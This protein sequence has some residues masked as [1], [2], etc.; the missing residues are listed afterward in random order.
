MVYVILGILIAFL[1]IILIYA[2]CHFKRLK[3]ETEEH[4]HIYFAERNLLIDQLRQQEELQCTTW[5][6]FQQVKEE[7]QHLIE[8]L[9]ELEDFCRN[10]EEKLAQ[11]KNRE[12]KEGSEQELD[13]AIAEK[14]ASI[15]RL[16]EV[17]VQYEEVAAQIKELM[18]EKLKVEGELE[19]TRSSFE[20]ADRKVRRIVERYQATLKV[21]DGE[22]DGWTFELS[23]DEIRL[24]ELIGEIG[25]MYRELREDLATIE[26]KKIW[27]PKLQDLNGRVGL[28]KRGIYCLEVKGSDGICYVGQAVNIKERWYQHVKK[29][30]GAMPK[31]N[32]KL[33]KFRP[34]DM[35]WKVLVSGDDID[36]NEEERFWIDSLKC[37]EIG[38]NRI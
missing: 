16:K 30:I 27:L 12:W 15:D 22:I 29:M 1:I 4:K 19:K 26:W 10:A 18:E 33:Y 9:K 2:F 14:Q 5:D 36:L 28:E 11:Y 32:E 35:V 21:E 24:I 3:N 37:K 13:N 20:E 23:R 25:G 17:S 31:G 6:N 8:E 38:L 34:E 7:N